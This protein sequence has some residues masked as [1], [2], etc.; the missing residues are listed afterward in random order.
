[1]HVD[2]VEEFDDIVDSSVYCCAICGTTQVEMYREMNTDQFE[3]SLQDCLIREGCHTNRHCM[4][5]ISNLKQFFFGNGC[6][7]INNHVGC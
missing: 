4:H 5:G 7:I 1:M 6:G 2:V 3:T